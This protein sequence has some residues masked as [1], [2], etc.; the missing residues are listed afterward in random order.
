MFVIREK[1][2]EEM[3]SARRRVLAPRIAGHVRLNHP[4]AVAG[5]TDE[6]LE[7]RVHARLDRARSY[8]MTWEKTLASFVS[9]TFVVGEHFDEHPAVRRVLN[10][11]SVPP[12]LRTDILVETLSDEEW[13]EAGRLR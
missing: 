2:A 5:I 8:G 1:Q 12:N 13:A 11:S 7:Q 9:L 3:R 6:E 4:E 10:D